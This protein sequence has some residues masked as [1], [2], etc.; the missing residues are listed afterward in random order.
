MDFVY[1]SYFIVEIVSQISIPWWGFKYFG[2]QTVEA[3]PHL[4]MISAQNPI[5][6]MHHAL[7]DHH[8][9][10]ATINDIK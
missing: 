1:W 8:T 6:D 7:S 3:I 10:V 9:D 5:R 2:C 4:G